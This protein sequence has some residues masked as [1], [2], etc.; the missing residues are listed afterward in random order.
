M[1]GPFTGHFIT[2]LS[3]RKYYPHFVDEKTEATLSS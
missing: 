3:K 2:V 1:L